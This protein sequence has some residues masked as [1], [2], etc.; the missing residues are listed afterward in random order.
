MQR[1][2]RPGT[3]LL[4]AAL[5]LY[6][7]SLVTGTVPFVVALSVDRASDLFGVWFCSF[8]LSSLLVTTGLIVTVVG[9]RRRRAGAAE[10]TRGRVGVAGWLT[11]GLTVFALTALPILFFVSG[12]LF[13]PVPY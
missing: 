5:G 3:R 11:I 8:L 2:G 12:V 7:A 1:E 10:Q 6:L 9:I 4:A 13:I